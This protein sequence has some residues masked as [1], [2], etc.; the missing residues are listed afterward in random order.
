MNTEC[1][2]KPQEKSFCSCSADELLAIIGKKWTVVILHLLYAYGPLGYNEMLKK[3]SKIAPKSFG[4]KL[5]LLEKRG[6]IARS[7]SEK[8]LRITYRLT[9]EGKVLFESL[10]PFLTIRENSIRP[11]I[12]A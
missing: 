1:C 9:P 4:D 5:K 8:P 12:T 2:L 7:V 6:L 3:I 11:G 10:H